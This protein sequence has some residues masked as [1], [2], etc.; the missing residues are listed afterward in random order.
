MY[1]NCFPKLFVFSPCWRV[2]FTILNYAKQRKN[3]KWPFYKKQMTCFCCFVY[4]NLT[5]IM[6][7]CQSDWFCWYIIGYSFL[8][9]WQIYDMF[10]FCRWACTF[11]NLINLIDLILADFVDYPLASL[12]INHFSSFQDSNSPIRIDP[13]HPHVCRKRRLKVALYSWLNGLDHET[14]AFKR[15]IHIL[16]INK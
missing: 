7:H 16:T 11:I 6:N 14:N 13:Q 1:E 15:Y 8:N 10:L 9:P 5:I 12:L 2:G 4:V 3:K